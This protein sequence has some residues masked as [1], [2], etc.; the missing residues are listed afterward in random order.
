[1]LEMGGYYNEA[2]FDQLELCAYQPLPERG[3]VP[4]RRGPGLDR[5]RHRLGGGTSINWTNC[6]RTYRLGARRVGARAR[7]RGPRRPRLRRPPGRG[8]RADRGQRRLLRPQRAA[9]AAAGGLRGARLRLPRDHP[10]HRPREATTR[11]PPATSASATS[12]GSK[13]STAKTYLADAQPTR[14]RDPRRLPR[15]A[16][17]GRERARRRGRGELDASD[18][19]GNGAAARVVVRA[20]TVVVACGSI[21]SPALLLRSGIGGPAVGDY[22][23]LHPTV[24]VTAYHDEPQDWWWGPPQAGALARVRRPRRRLRLPARVRAATDRALRR[25]RCPGAPAADHKQRMRAV[26]ARV[27]ADRPDPR[28]RPRP[29]HDRRRRQRRRP[30]PAH[31]RARRRA[32]SAAGSRS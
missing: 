26:G 3:P 5:R 6:L 17:P 10:Q 13:R 12:R 24:A 31:R 11:R 18:P 7:P 27:G 21:E 22:L 2:D 19:A 14:R 9:P 1:M 25:R 28:P 8:A 20:P 15:R 29:G 4:D 32:T 16:D 30:L 23:R